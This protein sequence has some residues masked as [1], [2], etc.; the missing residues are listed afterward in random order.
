MCRTCGDSTDTGRDGWKSDV[1]KR[2][3]SDVC[4]MIEVLQ[5]SRND[6]KTVVVPP[7]LRA[8]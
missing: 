1:K 5:D 8:F 3:K 2:R 4:S 7:F 6:G